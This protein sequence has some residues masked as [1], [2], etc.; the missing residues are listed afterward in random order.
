MSSLALGEIELD[1]L[2]V[3][4]Q[5]QVHRRRRRRSRSPARSCSSPRTWMPEPPPVSMLAALAASWSS[6][7]SPEV[8]DCA[9][10]APGLPVQRDQADLRPRARPGCRRGCD[11]AVDERQLMVFHEEELRR[12]WAAR[13]ACGSAGLKACS[14]GMGIDFQG[15]V[16][17]RFCIGCAVCA[18]AAAG[19]SAAVRSSVATK[20][21]R[22]KIVIAH[23][24]CRPGL[25]VSWAD[26]WTA[27]V[28]PALPVQP[29]WVARLRWRR[30]WRRKR[31]RRWRIRR[32]WWRRSDR[33]RRRVR[34]SELDACGGAVG[35]DEGLLRDAADVSLAHS[36]DLS[37]ARGTSRA[38]RRS[39]SGSRRAC[40]RGSRCRRGERSRS[41]R[42]RVLKRSSSASVTSVVFSL[43]SSL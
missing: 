34:R 43:S 42:A 24:H 4:V 3:G 27:E 2:E 25:L 5:Q 22:R 19:I 11:E 15:C 14:G 17:G 37:A 29:A 8:V 26:C 16:P 32:R 21:A 31:C 10:G 12:R 28:S 1:C 18:G 40:W 20:R 35:F 13:C 33:R 38:S 23:P 6:S 36:V 7:T 30:A 39:G 9:A 41:A